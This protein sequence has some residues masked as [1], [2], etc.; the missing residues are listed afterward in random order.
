MEKLDQ[1]FLKITEEEETQEKLEELEVQKAVGMNDSF[2]IVSNESV[3]DANCVSSTTDYMTLFM[4]ELHVASQDLHFTYIP[5]PAIKSNK[6]HSIWVG[7]MGGPGSG[8]STLVA[9][10]L[11]QLQP[12]ASTVIIPMDGYHYYKR[13][14]DLMENPKEAHARRGSIWTFNAAK[15]VE[16]LKKTKQNG[17][18]LFPSFDHSVGD[19]KENDIEVQQFHNIVI[20]E[21]NY[22]LCDDPY[23][24]DIKDLLDYSIFIQCNEN[25]FIPRLIKRHMLSWGINEEQARQRVYLNDKKNADYTVKFS[26]RA[27][28]VIKYE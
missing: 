9:L 24:K 17:Y 5:A 1:D 19:P 27:D 4:Q 16:D 20:L 22:L 11:K 18:G 21:G 13:E 14:L 23:W 12:F 8:K 7:I 10:L 15:F 3:E 26:E 6:S 2:V 28:L 25:I